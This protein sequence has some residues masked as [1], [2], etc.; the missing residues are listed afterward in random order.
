MVGAPKCRAETMQGVAW[1]AT[2]QGGTDIQPCPSGAS[3]KS[4]SIRLIHPTRSHLLKEEI[5]K[6]CLPKDYLTRVST[7]RPK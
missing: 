5:N 2:A 7:I 6:L 3:G 4:S 1:T